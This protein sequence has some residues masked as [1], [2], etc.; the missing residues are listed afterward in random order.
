MSQATR[1]TNAAH[2]Y[3]GHYEITGSV[4]VECNLENTVMNYGGTLGVPFLMNHIMENINIE[5]V[6]LVHDRP[7]MQTPL[8]K[9]QFGSSDF[10][11]TLQ[12]NMLCKLVNKA[13]VESARQWYNNYM[14][15]MQQVHPNAPR[16]S[17][18]N[19]VLGR[20]EHDHSRITYSDRPAVLAEI[21]PYLYT[22]GREYN[23]FLA[24]EGDH[25]LN[26]GPAGGVALTNK[27]G[28]TLGA[29]T[30]QRVL[31]ADICFGEFPEFL[32]FMM[33]AIEKKTFTATIAI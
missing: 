5:K 31:M 18:E 15:T 14:M 8:L 20:D 4:W 6:K 7:R 29:Y 10:H 13:D 17:F 25:N 3:C 11:H 2:S 22:Q 1:K 9:S 28:E 24:N 33:D 16:H 30:K 32:F 23:S 26:E 19:M 21:F 12:R 27:R